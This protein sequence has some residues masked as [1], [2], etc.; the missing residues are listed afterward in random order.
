MKIDWVRKLT[1]RKFWIAVAEFVTGLIIAFGGTQE[2]AV[3]VTALGYPAFHRFAHVLPVA[4]RQVAAVILSV[5]T[6]R[7]FVLLHA[8][9][10]FLQRLQVATVQT[11]A[12]EADDGI[13]DAEHDGERIDD[14]Q[15][16]RPEDDHWGEHCRQRQQHAA[17]AHPA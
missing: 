8:A 9:L 11:V 6:L 4:V 2:V 1:S 13:A 17:V 12:V 14:E 16:S 10:H 7:L 15:R 3:Q 5:Q